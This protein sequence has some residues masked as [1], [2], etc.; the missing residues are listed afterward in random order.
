MGDPASAPQFAR[1]AAE[2]ATGPERFE[3]WRSWHSTAVHGATTIERT[4]PIATDFDATAQQLTCGAVQLVELRNGPAS[5]GWTQDAT[6]AGDML[7]VV[8]FRSAPELRAHWNRAD[9]R[10]PASAGAWFRGS[11]WWYAPHGLRAVQV[12]VAR[13][14]VPLSERELEAA[15]SGAVPTGWPLF[16]QLLRPMLLGVSFPAGD[17]AATL[18]ADEPGAR[19]FEA[20]WSSAVTMLLSSLAS[21]PTDARET[22][23]VR[24]ALVLRHIDA[25]LADDLTPDSIA[26]ALGYSRRGLYGILDDGEPVGRLVLTRR[27]AQAQRL[28]IDPARRA[29]PIAAIGAEVGLRNAAH[30]SRAYRAEYGESPSETR[31]RAG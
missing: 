23:T 28:L 19:A 2:G 26:R 4:G 31:L 21:R 11:G 25:H 27:L 10:G 30:F 8:A 17:L 3:H 7:R 9:V 29:D 5:G 18:A 16:E 24:R 20:L 12:N 1:F 15:T 22:A 14:A 13:A 6:E